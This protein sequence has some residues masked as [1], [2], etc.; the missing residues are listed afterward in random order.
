[1]F[2]NYLKIGL[3]ILAKNRLASSINIFGLALAVG[4]CLVVFEFL[5]WSLHLDHFHA[6]I[7]RIFVVERI[8]EDNG[9]SQRYG[10]SPAPL[11]PLLQ[12]NF[13]AV[14]KVA[15]VNEVRAVIQ[16]NR[17][18]FNE[19]VS[20]VDDAFYDLFDFPVKWGQKQNFVE[21]DAIVLTHELAVKLFGQENPVGKTLS[22]RFNTQNQE[23]LENFTIRGV[24]AKRPSQTS[25]YFSA[26][27]PYRKLAALGLNKTNDW[28]QPVDI[29]FLEADHAAALAPVQNQTNEYVRLYNAANPNDKMAAF[30]FQSLRGINFQAYQVSNSKF[31]ATRPIGIIMLSVIAVA[32]LLLVYFNYTNIAIASAANRL[33][34]IGI[35]KM[36]GSSRKQIIFQFLVENLILCTVAVSL[37]L[38]LAKFVFLPLFSQIARVELGQQLFTN[39]RVWA[40]LLVLIGL[41]AL[42]G[43]AYP[44]FFISAFAPIRILKG[45]SKTGG[46]NRFRTLLLGFQFFLTFLAISLAVAFMQETK[47]AKARPWGYNPAHTV[48]VALDEAANFQVLKDQLKNNNAIQSVSGSVQ[49]LG[50]YTK[51]LVIKTEGK[52][53]TVPSLH[54]LPGFAGSLGIKIL[55]GR[56]LTEA[57]KT[58]QTTAVL[59][60]QAFLRQ[61]NWRTG[62][63]KTISSG[64]QTYTIVGEVN[65]FYFENFQSAVG[66]LL[67]L[68]CRPD[69]V[70]FAYV[71]TAPNVLANAH[72]AV[73]KE[74]KK[75]N[76]VLPFDYY[77]QDTVFDGYFQGFTQVSQVLGTASVL[78]ICISMFGIFGLALL[79]LSKKMKEISVRKVLGAGLGHISFLINK[80]FIVAIAVASAVGFPLAYWVTSALFHQVSPG[81][82][83]SFFPL[84][85]SFLI[86]ISMTVIS[87]SWHLFKVYTANPTKYLKDE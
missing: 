59:V 37:G 29:T 68:G 32:I 39:Y 40:A 51:Q 8:S 10:N 69:E 19:S 72:A 26:L 43:A 83:V 28:S 11:G 3:R 87:V 49:S 38:L 45:N 30:Y 44:S 9:R 76:P 74:W 85:L 82:T 21:P 81:S 6:K 52:E 12:Q 46:K 56:D 80:E 20:F 5:D 16:Q 63:G 54:V 33:K 47:R 14:K 48:V 64:N 84:I 62:I 55:K 73:E 57:F 36:M 71:K 79:I 2:Q 27:I 31:H 25:F 23:L 86:L 70:K 75:V 18:V 53:Q 1:M 13:P 22:I 61:M 60:N 78:M 50:N 24:F 58:D 4:C 67:L 42:S 17:N 41:S 34:E 77:Y 66:P 65:D 15:R 7:N 35:R